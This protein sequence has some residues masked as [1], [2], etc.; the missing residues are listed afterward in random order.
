MDNEHGDQDI[1]ESLIAEWEHE[2]APG[3]QSSGVSFS[4]WHPAGLS[5][6]RSPAQDLSSAKENTPK[7]KQ[8]DASRP[9]SPPTNT[10]TSGQHGT[11]QD[12]L[13]RLK[14]ELAEKSQ[15]LA[16]LVEY[17]DTSLQPWTVAITDAIKDLSARMGP[18]LRGLGM[19]LFA[20]GLMYSWFQHARILE[21]DPVSL[22]ENPV[23]DEPVQTPVEKARHSPGPMSVLTKSLSHIPVRNMRAWVTRDIETRHKETAKNGRISRPMNSFLLYRSAYTER[24]KAWSADASHIVVSK[25]SGQ[26]W[27]KEPAHIREEYESLALIERHNHFMAYPNYKFTPK[28][29]KKR[30]PPRDERSEGMKSNHPDAPCPSPAFSRRTK[31]SEPNSSYTSRASTP[32][33]SHGYSLGTYNPPSLQLSSETR[34]TAAPHISPSTEAGYNGFSPSG[35]QDLI[36]AQYTT[37]SLARTPQYLQSSP[38]YPICHAAAHLEGP[39]SYPHI[40]NSEVPG[41]YLYYISQLGI[42]QM[43]L[44]MNPNFIQTVANTDYETMGMYTTDSEEE[45]RSS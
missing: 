40:L 20:T 8:T 42:R 4:D 38:S 37:S 11:L 12:D 39:Q 2:I 6:S 13:E 30:K 26:S 21:L 24:I 25:I 28:P 32:A 27:L 15:M 18:H 33:E 14:R 19:D 22:S 31:S 5:G 29:R 3:I 45:L 35:H 9:L 43:H 7:E 17:V 16:E 34:F 44:S 41:D 1:W 23:K 36:N 10:E